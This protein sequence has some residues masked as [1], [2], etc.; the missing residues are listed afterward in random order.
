MEVLIYGSKMVITEEYTYIEGVGV[1]VRETNTKG[2]GVSWLVNVK[3]MG[4]CQNLRSYGARL[5]QEV[6]GIVKMMIRQIMG[7]EEQ[8]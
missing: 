6:D 5:V 1:G 4:K 7:R 2:E 3:K 8:L